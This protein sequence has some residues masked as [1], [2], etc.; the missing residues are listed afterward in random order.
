MFKHI[1]TQTIKTSRLY[2]RKFIAN[3]VDDVYKNWASNSKIQ[4]EYGEPVYKTKKQVK[5]L[6]SK[7]ILN[8]NDSNF[9]RWAIILKKYNVNI[10][11]IGFC[12]IY[13]EIATAEIEYC[14][15]EKY[16]G[17]GYALESLNAVIEYMLVNSDFEK[18][19]AFHRKI[20]KQSG[21][22]LEKTAMK[23][24]H[25]VRRFELLGKIPEE[26]VCYSI[27]KSEY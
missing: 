2:L 3:D 15:S 8:Y 21:R 22:V 12:R 27:S 1:G 23:K 7:L 16:W 25:N 24:V 19:E 4:L 18:L 11:Q 9:Y 20:N 5:E 13:D 6:L 10:G 26:E 17:N 14:I